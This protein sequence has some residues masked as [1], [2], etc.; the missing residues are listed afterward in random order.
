MFKTWHNYIIKFPSWYFMLG[1]Q[2]S[3]K[4]EKKSQWKPHCHALSTH[5][6]F[7]YCWFTSLFTYFLTELH[8]KR[9][10]S[11]DTNLGT[12]VT[13]KSKMMVGGQWGGG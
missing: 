6:Y 1:S 10:G 5:L 12:K 3:N 8:R 2:N 11:Q 7:A 4:R 13:L 9:P